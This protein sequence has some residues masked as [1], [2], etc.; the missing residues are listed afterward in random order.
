MPPGLRRYRRRPKGPK[1]LIVG[2]ES[3]KTQ[4]RGGKADGD[5]AAV[6]KGYVLAGMGRQFDLVKGD[7]S[8]DDRGV[9]KGQAKKLGGQWGAVQDRST[10]RERSRSLL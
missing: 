10:I 8:G 5:W 3:R 1:R 7:A 2:K 4:N 9:G 6:I